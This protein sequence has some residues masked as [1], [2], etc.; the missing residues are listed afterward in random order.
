MLN[1][2]N[3]NEQNSQ[4]T[5]MIRNEKGALSH[6]TTGDGRV[7]LFYKTIRGLTVD[8]LELYLH[9]SWRES[10]LDTLKLIH[11]IRDCRGKGKGEKKLC[12][13]AYHWLLKHH[14]NQVSA[15][16]IHL[17][18]YGCYKDWL[19]CF[20]GNPSFE[21][22][23]LDVLATQLQDDWREIVDAAEST[24]DLQASRN[25][26]LLASRNTDL[27]DK[28]K[29]E[30]SNQPPKIKQ[31]KISLAWKWTPTE[32]C[33]FDKKFGL[34]GKLCKRMNINKKTYRQRSKV[35]RAIL[36]VVEQQ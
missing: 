23:M 22:Q 17:P 16:F 36:N 33:S 31:A 2:N 35:A 19:V 30:E 27:Q 20:A 18:F 15:N 6:A 26:D 21:G 9:A 32:N 28:G 3:S 1:P 25:T 4:T 14:P 8:Q 24:A 11:F 10:E 5:M 7:D 12:F 13:D 29:G 34:V